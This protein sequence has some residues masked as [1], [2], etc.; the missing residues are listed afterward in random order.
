[1]QCITAELNRHNVAHNEKI[2]KLVF[3][4]Y[5]LISQKGNYI[6]KFCFKKYSEF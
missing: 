5:Y 6:S 2:I 4:H 1:M 3:A